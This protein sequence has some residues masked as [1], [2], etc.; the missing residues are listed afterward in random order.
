[1]T[2]QTPQTDASNSKTLG[3]GSKL[4]VDIGPAAVF[5]ITYNVAKRLVEDQAIYWATGVFMI[6]TAAAVIYA[7]ITQKRFP[8]MLAVTFVIVT[9]FGGMTIYLQDP[10]FIFIKPTIINLIFSFAI[11]ISFALG[12]NV[13]KALFGSIY[14][15]PDHAWVMLGIRW[16]LFF[17]ALALLNEVMWRHIVDASVDPS[18]RWFDGLELTESFWVN[19]RFFGVF[20]IFF[21]F[22]LA[23]VPLTLKFAKAAE[24]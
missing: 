13:W 21:V 1:M 23:N 16:A 11:L 8:P 10:I 24:D 22:V 19:F 15:M 14:S 9:L 6:A 3:Q 17:A 20:P 12:F 7:L 18:M 5:M 2:D 4:L